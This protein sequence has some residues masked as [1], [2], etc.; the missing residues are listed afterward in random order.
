MKH[1]NHQNILSLKR[2][3]F[4]AIT[5][6]LMAFPVRAQAPSEVPLR[7]TPMPVAG[8]GTSL[9]VVN[10]S[11]KPIVGF[12]VVTDFVR[13]N[14][15]TVHK[16]AQAEVRG[17]MRINGNVNFLLPGAEI[18][19]RPAPD[20]STS[21]GEALKQ[22]ISLDLVV[23]SD[24]SHWG[25]EADFTSAWLRGSIEGMRRQRM[26]YQELLAKQGLAALENELSDK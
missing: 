18:R 24:G 6:T 19:T 25:R 1:M 15:T 22:K 17:D 8:I 5:C 21:T 13:D 14:G 9:H 20:P 2:I 23:F 12:V 7:I 4:T 10:I 16:T 3:P 26:R 11:S